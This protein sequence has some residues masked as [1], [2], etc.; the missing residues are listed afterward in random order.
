[1]IV[2]SEQH[3]VLLSMTY[4]RPALRALLGDGL[5]EAEFVALKRHYLR[6]RREAGGAPRGRE[7]GGRRRR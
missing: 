4:S 3:Q 7:N 2:T 6:L 1:M 5:T